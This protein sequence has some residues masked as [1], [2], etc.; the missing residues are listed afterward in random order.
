MRSARKRRKKRVGKRRANVSHRSTRAP[1]PGKAASLGAAVLLAVLIALGAMELIRAALWTGAH[2]YG[3]LSVALRGLVVLTLVGLL[4]N[5]AETA[6]RR[7]RHVLA[8]IGAPLQFILAGFVVFSLG[9]L[10][11]LRSVYELEQAPPLKL[12]I[13]ELAT[14][15]EARFVTFNDAVLRPELHFELSQ[16]DANTE[17]LEWFTATAITGPSYQSGEIIPLWAVRRGKNAV[18]T[19]LPAPIRGG[20]EARTSLRAPGEEAG[21]PIA[22]APLILLPSKHGYDETIRRYRAQGERTL[23]WIGGCLFAVCLLTGTIR[24]ITA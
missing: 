15:P 5:A 10:G 12:H 6:P 9:H 11:G 16:E 17:V 2:V 20:V 18:V 3:L 8:R 22:K 13:D 4:A 23:L 24:V 19:E 1:L 21:L 7:L 14:H